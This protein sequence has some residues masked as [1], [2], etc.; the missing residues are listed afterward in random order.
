MCIER[1]RQRALE[2]TLQGAFKKHTDFPSPWR[3]AFAG[4]RAGCTVVMV[5]L[6]WKKLKPSIGIWPPIAML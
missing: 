3:G 1:R 2:E 6:S 4:V 5:W